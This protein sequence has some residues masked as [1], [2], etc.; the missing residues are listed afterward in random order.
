MIA[1]HVFI[2]VTPHVTSL[3]LFA[4]LTA[5]E[6]GSTSESER[7][8]LEGGYACIYEKNAKIFIKYVGKP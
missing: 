3:A 5:W 4:D 7:L 1:R 8:L 6:T 2:N